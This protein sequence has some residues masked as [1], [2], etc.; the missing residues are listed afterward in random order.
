MY[1][2]LYNVKYKLYSIS[3]CDADVLWLFKWQQNKKNTKR[4][5]TIANFIYTNGTFCQLQHIRQWL[6]WTSTVE[7]FFKS[8]SPESSILI[9]YRCFKIVDNRVLVEGSGLKNRKTLGILSTYRFRKS[10]LWNN[11]VQYTV[12]SIFY[13]YDEFTVLII[14]RMALISTSCC[15]LSLNKQ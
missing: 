15:T 4:D 3:N 9:L 2:T 13:L 8:D 5:S 12:R 1:C 10:L 7:F 11:T 6:F 14:K